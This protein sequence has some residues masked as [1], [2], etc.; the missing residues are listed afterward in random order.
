MKFE[1]HA[2][3]K[4]VTACR[5]TGLRHRLRHAHQACLELVAPDGTRWEL[6]L[7]DIGSGGVCFGLKDGNPPMER[8]TEIA[9]VVVRV[10]GISITGSLSI[11]HATEEFAAGT[12]CGARFRP[13]GPQDQAALDQ[14]ILSLAS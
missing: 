6:D 2:P 7:L 5:R 8:G 13:A 1:G 11:A 12:I 4:M 14:I 9:G 3:P 10:G